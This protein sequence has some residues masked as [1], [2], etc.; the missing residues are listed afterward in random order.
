MFT[1]RAGKLAASCILLV[2]A[3][4]EP[5]FAQEPGLTP[6]EIRIGT[7]GALTGP[8]YLYGKLVMNGVEIVFD[9][10]NSSGGIHGRR[11]VLVREDD[12][13]DPAAAIA[14]V[15]KLIYQDEVFALIGGGCSN[16]TYAARDTIE[17]AKIPTLI[18]ASVHDGITTPPAENI[19]STALTSSIESQAQ[20]AFALQ[21]D[22][23][24]IAVISMRDSWGRARYAP[25]I[26]AFKAKG[27]TPVADEELSPDAN[28]ATAQVLRLKQANADAVIMLLYPKPAAIFM[29]DAHKLGFKPLD[30]GQSGIADP[31]AFEEQV[32]VPGATANFRTI[33]MVK[34]TPDDPAVDKWRKLIE[35][36][37]PGDRL[38]VYN[39][40]GVGSA[41][42]FI[43]ALEAAGAN[44]T[45][46]GLVRAFANIKN[47]HTD[48]YPGPI[49]CS[50]AD[51]RCNK[52]PAWLAKAP[53]G[54]VRVMAVT[55]VEH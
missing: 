9:E 43:A 25:L 52:N 49:T 37:F 40:F 55:S 24:R 1:N 48:V 54:P 22:A 27:V 4:G 26:E 17:K 18:F 15:Q 51:H 50:L 30:I 32:G 12:R 46:E 29:R 19:F 38:S 47:L 16:A 5:A 8:G 11:L 41:Q 42:V 33:S 3:A 45:R 23:K 35:A 28:D 39:L 13:C 10:V 44:P 7:F 14:A 34:Y 53:G 6:S 20:L 21:Q 2:L 36:K 31:I